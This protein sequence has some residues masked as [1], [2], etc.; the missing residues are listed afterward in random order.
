MTE[1]RPRTP[2]TAALLV[3]ITVVF[4]FEWLT[5]ALWS[6]Q[7]LRAMGAIT[8]DMLSSGQYWRIFAAMFLHGNFVHWLANCWA[9]FQLGTLFEA[10]FG[11]RRFAFVYFASG[12]V[13][14]IASSLSTKGLS[15]GASGAIFGILGAFIFTIRRSPRYRHE[16]WTKGFIGQLVFWAAINLAFGLQVPNID[17]VA[18]MA[19]LATGLILG[20]IPHRVPPPPPGGTTIETTAMPS[21]GRG[22]PSEDRRTSRASLH[23][24][25]TFSGS[26][27]SPAVRTIAR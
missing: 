26:P 6:E 2:V 16:Y 10:M 13:A 8:P 22:V 24:V 18:H 15:V 1:R 4:A 9:L 17:N 23:S 19:G 11:S 5:G 21:D 25:T 14:S 7:R 20:F 3:T 27:V 12:A